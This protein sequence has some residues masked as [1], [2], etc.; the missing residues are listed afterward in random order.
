MHAWVQKILNARLC[1][2]VGG[3][4]GAA[5]LRS[6][7]AY[8]PL[9]DSWH[10]IRSMINPRSNFGIEVRQRYLS[11]EN[12]AEIAVFEASHWLHTDHVTYNYLIC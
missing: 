8:N 4:D 9:N 5:R 1:F 11:N 10:D 7:E 6:A 12:T 3:F 2:K